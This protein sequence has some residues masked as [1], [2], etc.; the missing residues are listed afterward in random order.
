MQSNCEAVQ[1]MLLFSKPVFLNGNDWMFLLR[2]V[3]R[4][5]RE[6]IRLLIPLRSIPR[7]GLP[8]FLLS[9][10]VGSLTSI[11]YQSMS[12]PFQ[13]AKWVAACR[14]LPARGTGEGGCGA[15]GEAH[16]QVQ[17]RGGPAAAEGHVGAPA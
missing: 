14:H 6:R 17:E 15:T 7:P 11:A 12:A 13:T 8:P 16:W 3:S 2:H 5:V 1:Q 10:S 4:R 9:P